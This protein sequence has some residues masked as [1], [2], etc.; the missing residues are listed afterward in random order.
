MSKFMYVFLF[1]FIQNTNIYANTNKKK[2]Q[3][4]I[5]ELLS[6]AQSNLI[7]L[8]DY[9]PQLKTILAQLDHSSDNSEYSDAPLNK[10]RSFSNRQKSVI[11][12]EI[13]SNIRARRTSDPV[14]RSVKSTS[15]V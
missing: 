12:I 6:V 4:T 8:C 5:C 7:I 9:E 11:G 3:K 1:D 2:T 13:K 10:P 15:S 14:L